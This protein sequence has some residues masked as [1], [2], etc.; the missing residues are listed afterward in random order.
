MGTGHSERYLSR[1]TGNGAC[2]SIQGFKLGEFGFSI[3]MTVAVVRVACDSG[4]WLGLLQARR[5]VRQ[6]RLPRAP[7]AKFKALMKFLPSGNDV[8]V[9]RSI[10]ADGF[11]AASTSTTTA[12]S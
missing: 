8:T 7:V 1:C 6:K 2:C 12:R 3:E 9:I 10:Q 4:L 11:Y 5:F